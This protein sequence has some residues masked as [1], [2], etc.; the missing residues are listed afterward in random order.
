[1]DEFLLSVL[2]KAYII[3]KA[4][5][6]AV[7][8]RERSRPTPTVHKLGLSKSVAILTNTEVLICQED[9]LHTLMSFTG[10]DFG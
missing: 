7:C 8:Y 1:M 5:L 3:T 9:S 4:D 2:A 10:D 6:G